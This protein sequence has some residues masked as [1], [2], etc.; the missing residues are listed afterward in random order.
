MGDFS[1][2]VAPSYRRQ[3]TA[4]VIRVVDEAGTFVL[5]RSSAL[6]AAVLLRFLGNAPDG[7]EPSTDCLEGSCSIQL[8]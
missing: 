3:L 4:P 7:F 2:L 5:S 6:F 1:Y 8:S